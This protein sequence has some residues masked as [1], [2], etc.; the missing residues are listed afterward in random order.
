MLLNISQQIDIINEAIHT[1]T[2]II[3]KIEKNLMLR[4]QSM[5]CGIIN[6]H[7]GIDILGLLY[8][9]SGCK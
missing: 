6:F 8:Y 3:A 9:G 7:R 5:I 2:A 4:L 1:M